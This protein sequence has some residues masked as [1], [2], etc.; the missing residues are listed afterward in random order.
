[1]SW[2]RAVG[3]LVLFILVIACGVAVILEPPRCPASLSASIGHSML[4]AGCE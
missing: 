1:M 2:G 3:V 4:L